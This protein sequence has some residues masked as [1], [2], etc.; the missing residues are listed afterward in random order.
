VG[1]GKVGEGRSVG[2][3]LPTTLGSAAAVPG[4]RPNGINALR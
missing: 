3:G 2:H 1:H 4:D